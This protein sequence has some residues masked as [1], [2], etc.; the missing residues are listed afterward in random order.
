MKPPV[1]D[2]VDGLRVGVARVVTNPECEIAKRESIAV[3]D[4]TEDHAELPTRLR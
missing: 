1:G 4:E 3:A 2:G